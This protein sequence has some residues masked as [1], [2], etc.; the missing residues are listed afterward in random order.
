MI[1]WAVVFSNVEPPEVYSLWWTLAQAQEERMRVLGTVT[2][3]DVRVLEM[4]IR[5]ERPEE[6]NTYI[7]TNEELAS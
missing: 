3:A 5:G 6:T 2:H 7:T 4:E 1:I